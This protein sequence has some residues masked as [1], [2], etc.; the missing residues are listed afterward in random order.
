M[1]L[2][3]SGLPFNFFFSGGIVVGV[4]GGIG[5]YAHIESRAWV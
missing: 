5:P 4:M 2:A 1:S 3:S